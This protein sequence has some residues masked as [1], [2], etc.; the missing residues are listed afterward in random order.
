MTGQNVT[1]CIGWSCR[2]TYNDLNTRYHTQCDP[3]LNA[4]QSLELAFII[5]ERLKK[6][7]DRKRGICFPRVNRHLESLTSTSVYNVPI[8]FFCLYGYISRKYVDKHKTKVLAF[9]ASQN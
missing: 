7:E 2:I 3:R 9:T 1:K 8:Y 6:K 5:A 4:S